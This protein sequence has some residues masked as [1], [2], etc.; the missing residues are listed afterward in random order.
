MKAVPSAFHVTYTEG[1]E[2][3]RALSAPTLNVHFVRCYPKTHEEEAVALPVFGA[4]AKGK[5]GASEA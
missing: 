5:G 1:G 4:A 2:E 3:T